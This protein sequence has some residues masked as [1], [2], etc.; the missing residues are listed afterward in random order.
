MFYLAFFFFFFIITSSALKGSKLKN[1]THQL[2]EAETVGQ[3]FVHNWCS[4]YI[5]KR[6]EQKVNQI[7]SQPKHQVPVLNGLRVETL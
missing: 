7:A 4:V 6:N 1:W 3:C 2:L 5:C